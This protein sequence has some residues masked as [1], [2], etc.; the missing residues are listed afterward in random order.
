MA[1]AINISLNLILI[2][3][4][5]IKGAAIANASTQLFTA[6]YQVILTRKIFKLRA[7]A[8]FTI[9]LAVFILMLAIATWL[10]RMLPVL[11]FYS[12]LLLGIFG[13]LLSFVLRLIRPVAFRQI[14]ET[15]N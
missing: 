14:L 15:D 5:G 12:A 4:L 1:V 8:G 13:M 11:W 3:R 2:P 7:N 6:V 10:F 9:R